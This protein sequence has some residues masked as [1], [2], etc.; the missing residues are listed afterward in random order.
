MLVISLLGLVLVLIVGVVI[1][2]NLSP[3]MGM[4]PKGADLIR[5][6]QSP[7][8]GETSFVNLVQ[9]TTGDIWEALTKMPEMYRSKGNEPTQPLPSKF[10]LLN[11]SQQIDSTYITWF[12]HSSFLIEMQGKR[13]L[14]DPMFGAVASPIPLGSKRF[15]YEQPIPVEELTDIDVVLISHDHYDHLDYPT[16]RKIKDK[17]SLFI[18]PLGVGSH[19]KRWGVP[20][21]HIVELDWWQAH[22]LEDLNFTATPARHFSGRGLTDKD[23][24]QW[25]GWTLQSEQYNLYFSGDSGY[26]THFKTIGEQLGP[27]DFAM[28]ECGQYNQ[29]W[30]EIHMMPEESVQAAK[31]V[32]ARIAMP[33]HWGAF[34]LAP[35][36]WTDSMD[37]F[38]QKAITEKLPYIVPSIGERFS[39]N[40]THHHKKWWQ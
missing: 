3:Q 33:I 18:T 10:S 13:I 15:T 6:Q 31:D 8:Y 32:Q 35:H 36:G 7:N 12:G 34:R 9:T 38:E 28:I 22:L 11:A 4:P 23:A 26:G 37:R 19:L 24:T 21:D 27:F 5:M 2:V 30:S 40:K 20:A 29:A 17:V 39:L 14:I 1:F 25:A 16:I